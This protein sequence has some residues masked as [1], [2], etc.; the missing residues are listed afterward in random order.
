[1]TEAKT[2]FKM[3]IDASMDA[4]KIM[5]IDAI[6]ADMLVCE[7]LIEVFDE[8]HLSIDHEAAKAIWIF[9]SMNHHKSA[10]ADGGEVKEACFQAVLNMAYIFFRPGEESLQEVSE[11]Q[12]AELSNQNNEV[13]S[14]VRK[15]LELNENQQK[16]MFEYIKQLSGNE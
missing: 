8:M 13:G 4:A 14:T 1:M 10:W 11:E 5:D 9:Y 6:K 12:L 16:F 2:I 3:V 15:L 7:N